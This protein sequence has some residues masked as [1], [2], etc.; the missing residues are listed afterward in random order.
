MP[1]DIGRLT[2]GPNRIA[3]RR[4]GAGPPLLLVHGWPFHGRT[5][6]GILPALRERFTCW[7]PDLPGLGLTEWSEDTDFSFRGQARTLRAFV[8]AAGLGPY[9]VIAHD[10]GGTIA[11]LAASDDPRVER[12]VVLN[13]EMPGHRP[14]FI[15]LFQRTAALPGAA[16]NFRLTLGWRWYL[17][18]RIGFGGCFRDRS[19]IDDAFVARYV[20]PLRESPRRLDGVLRYLRGIDWEVVDALPAIHRRITAPARLVWGAADPTFPVALARGMLPQFGGGADL[21]EVP[22]ACLLVQEE[23]P[24]DVARAVLD[25]IPA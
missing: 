14:P 21:V 19:R 1:D 20:T 13:T 8:D 12:L 7:V 4:L 23:R 16:G 6:D 17:R 11:R 5:W 25:F 3:F 9:S 10:T 2:V 24:A 18:S 22:D 15:P